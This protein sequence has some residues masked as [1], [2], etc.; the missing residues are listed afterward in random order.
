M[1]RK[2]YISL[3]FFS[4]IFLHFCS[5]VSSQQRLSNLENKVEE[6]Q[7]NLQ[8]RIEEV[9]QKKD[10]LVAQ[11]C[12]RIAGTIS[13]K[14]DFHKEIREKRVASLQR[15]RDN[16]RN[17]ID[18][19]ESAG[20]DTSNLKTELQKLEQMISDFSNLNQ[21]II[22]SLISSGELACAENRNQFEQNMQLLRTYWSELKNRAQEIRSFIQNTILPEI[23]NIKKDIRN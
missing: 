16:I 8:K 3:L 20:I 14:V 5:P 9:R 21:S 12:E 15:V 13:A 4:V 2:F 6:K 11:R 17:I 19:L 10:S 22:L 7:N 1:N 23:D 18:R